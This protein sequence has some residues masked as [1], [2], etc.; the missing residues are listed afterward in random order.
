MKPPPPREPLC[1]RRFLP[2][3]HPVYP[4]AHQ[5]HRRRCHRRPPTPRPSTRGLSCVGSTRPRHGLSP[6]IHMN[7]GVAHCPQCRSSRVKPRYRARKVGSAIGTLA[8]AAAGTARIAGAAKLG[9][10]FGA[11]LGFVAGP[12]GASIGAIAGAVLGSMVGAAAGCA[13]GA[14]LGNAI[15]ANV[16]D[17]HRCL[18]CGCGFSCRMG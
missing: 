16:L 9:A 10:E 4:R 3:R 18:A 6:G 13:V 12:G 1:L 8:G 7:P 5:L 2:G 15:D 17:N 14:A 11:T